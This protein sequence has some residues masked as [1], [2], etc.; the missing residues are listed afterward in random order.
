MVSGLEAR[1]MASSEEE[2][3]LIGELVMRFKF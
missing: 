3:M 2:V 1:L